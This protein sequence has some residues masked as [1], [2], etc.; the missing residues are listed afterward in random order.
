[1]SR[2]ILFVLFAGVTAINTGAGN[3]YITGIVYLLGPVC[4]IL[5]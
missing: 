2:C 4:A 5:P 1:M 3:T